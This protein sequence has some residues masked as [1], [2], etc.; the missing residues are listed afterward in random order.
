MYIQFTIKPV[1]DLKI[2]KTLTF[3]LS[4]DP[5]KWYPVAS[6]QGSRFKVIDESSLSMEILIWA[7]SRWLKTVIRPTDSV[8]WGHWKPVSVPAQS[9]FSRLK[10]QIW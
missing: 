6:V 2:L 7:S 4:L 9:G 5:A 1:Q 8:I 10:I 3:L